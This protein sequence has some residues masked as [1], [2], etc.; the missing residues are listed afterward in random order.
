MR[1]E[2]Q[3]PRLKAVSR[4][5]SPRAE[6]ES[7]EAREPRLR[8]KARESKP[9]KCP[10]L[11]LLLGVASAR[12][13]T[14]KGCDAIFGGGNN[15]GYDENEIV[16]GN[17]GYSMSRQALQDAVGRGGGFGGL[18]NNLWGSVVDIYGNICEVT[19]SGK[20][21]LNFYPLPHQFLGPTVA[22]CVR[23]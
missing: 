22:S 12:R 8:A 21:S 19:F 13:M 6:A 11:L 15:E 1:A 7:R 20:S 23:S 5:P 2:S 3:E 9:E 18:G 4:E 17:D 10:W 16:G 14:N